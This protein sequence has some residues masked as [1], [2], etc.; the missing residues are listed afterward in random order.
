MTSDLA[1]LSSSPSPP[2]LSRD[3]KARFERESYKKGEVVFDALFRCG[4][5]VVCVLSDFAI[6]PD[7]F[8]LLAADT[9]LGEWYMRREIESLRVCLCACVCE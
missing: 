7:L 9:P 5:G 1:R 2:V 8:S 4:E 3:K 6:E